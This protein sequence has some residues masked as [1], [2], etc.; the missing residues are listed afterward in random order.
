MPALPITT[1]L[2]KFDAIF[3]LNQ[4]LLLEQQYLSETLST[5]Q[6]QKR[7]HV[8]GM[9]PTMQPPDTPIKEVTEWCPKSDASKFTVANDSQLF[10]TSWIEQL[11]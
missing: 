4:D 11:D 8:P 9:E 3:T 5:I 7:W 1:F 2:S 6:F 10:Q